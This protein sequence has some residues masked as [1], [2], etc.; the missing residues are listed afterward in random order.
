ML[1]FV[2]E[3]VVMFR[4]Y[5]FC[6]SILKILSGTEVPQV[7]NTVVFYEYLLPLLLHVN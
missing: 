5:L 3:M 1:P 4:F 2:T 6:K 7:T